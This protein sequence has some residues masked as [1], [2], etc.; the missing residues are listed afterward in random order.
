LDAHPEVAV[1]TRLKEVH[2]FD[3]QYERGV[4]WYESFFPRGADASKYKAAGEI[5]PHYL[6]D[7]RCP[8]RIAE[9]S[10]VRGLI[11]MLR[12][13]VDRAFSHYVWRVRTRGYRGPFERFLED[14]PDAV[15]WGRYAQRLERFLPRFP[16]SR[17]LILVHEHV[18]GDVLAA[19]RRIAE[20]LEIDDGRFPA[21]AGAGKVNPGTV[22]RFRGLTR[23]VSQANFQLKRRDIYW[24]SSLGEKLGVKRLL[25]LPAKGPAPQLPAESA[26]RLRDL[27]AGDVERLEALTGLDLVVWKEP[28]P[29][30]TPDQACDQPQREV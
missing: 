17:I 10:S 20:F 26:A 8:A 18:F 9:M 25:R 23:L 21:G 27:F 12:N 5:T 2:F 3:V 14:V 19:Q 24:I 22:P 1:P 13:P 15:R 30:T 29:M 6:Y 7:D 11:L 16:L 28:P 4:T